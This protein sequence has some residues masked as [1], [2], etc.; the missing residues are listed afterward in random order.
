MTTLAITPN[1]D[2]K[3]ARFRGTVAA[4]EHVEVT[5]ANDGAAVADTA[6]LRLRVVG[7]D[8]RTLAQFPMPETPPPT[9]AADVPGEDEEV[10][11]SF[12][13]PEEDNEGAESPSVADAWD[14][15]MTPLKCTLN[16]NTV[17]MLRAVPPGANVQLWWVL[18]DYE[19]KTLYFKEMFSVEHWPRRRGEEEPVDLDDYADLIKDFTER[20][21]SAETTVANASEQATTAAQR[22]SEALDT[23]ETF[24]DSA[25]ACASAAQAS[26]TAAGNARDAAQTAERNAEGHKNA[27]ATS[28]S[29]AAAAQAA[30]EEAAE[31]AKEALPLDDTLSETGK[32]ADAKAVGDAVR[33][34]NQRATTAESELSGRIDAEAQARRLLA[35]TV[36]TNT[37][38]IATN[39]SSLTSLASRV[40]ENET[41]I[42]NRYTKAEVNELLAGGGVKVRVVQELPQTGEE[43]VLYF[44]P[45]TGET[46]D[47]YDEYMWIA[48]KWEKIGS[49]VVDLS[50]YPTKSEVDAGWWSEWELFPSIPGAKTFYANYAYD[51][52]NVWFESFP[53]DYDTRPPDAQDYNSPEDATSLS[54]SV[55]SVQYTAT[56]HRVAAPVP[57]KPGD[58]G[59]Q[60]A[61]NYLTQHQQLT[62]V[63]SDGS[64]SD[65]IQGWKCTPHIGWEPGDGLVSVVWVPYE[66]NPGG[67]WEV[68]FN[69]YGSKYTR[70]VYSDA[71]ALEL[72][73]D[74]DGSDFTLTRGNYPVTG[75]VLGTQT[76]K[77]LQPKGDYALKS[78][79]P[80]VPVQSVNGKTG[81]VVLTGED[82]R[83][84]NGGGTIA[85]E[86]TLSNSLISILRATK[87]STGALA[88]Q[89]FDF[90]AMSGMYYAVKALV[91]ALGGTVTNFPNFQV[92]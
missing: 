71:D 75:Y 88:G 76:D 11:P 91:G 54:F 19:N 2:R 33:A 87:V 18:D 90:A 34:A 22:V 57:T 61:G 20:L 14:E 1:Y 56:R 17:Q 21:E 13:A 50:N 55:S 42:A 24:V 58:I 35:A 78:E 16:L 41:A 52:W 30:A 60:P 46:G 43:K 69:Y 49:T 15:D 74:F 63:Y 32:A 7:F 62:P 38:N 37:A 72:L 77:P 3:T 10:L 66:D 86:I 40:G 92:N 84:Q 70:T 8:G 36:Q 27:A 83:W 31:E 4:G 48:A 25:S 28:A 29:N 12:E 45:K 53:G 5:I 64:D 81:A 67:I 65:I 44:V 23:A 68:S 85:S 51:H 79:L 6:S 59:A 39:A 73:F 9:D 80:S 26:A 89:S 82:I 47:V